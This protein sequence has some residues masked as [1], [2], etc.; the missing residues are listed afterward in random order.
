MRQ[1]ILEA[2][3]YPETEA[4]DW[5]AMGAEALRMRASGACSN[6]TSRVEL[7]AK[8]KEKPVV[9]REMLSKTKVD[10]ASEAVQ[11][12]KKR[13]KVKGATKQEDK[14]G[15]D[16]NAGVRRSKRVRF[17]NLMGEEYDWSSHAT[18]TSEESG[19]R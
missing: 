6:P 4:E 2:D 1:I 8:S 3:N 5:Q 18:T 12:V 9:L 19:L 7:T 13:M 11:Q 16:E 10:S 14:G 17:A 15:V